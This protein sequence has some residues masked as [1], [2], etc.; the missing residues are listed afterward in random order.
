MVRAELISAKEFHAG[1]SHHP[2]VSRRGAFHRGELGVGRSHGGWARRPHDDFRLSAR[3]DEHR[4]QLR[5]RSNAA[6]DDEYGAGSEVPY[7]TEV[8]T[9]DAA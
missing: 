9:T 1:A 6:Q 8:V 7:P 3:G 4:Q 5:A 2:A